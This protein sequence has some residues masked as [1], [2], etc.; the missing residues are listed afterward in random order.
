MLR[1]WRPSRRLPHPSWQS[2]RAPVG[3]LQDVKSEP[4]GL[5]TAAI[6][7]ARYDIPTALAEMRIVWSDLCSP[8]LHSFS[9]ADAR[10]QSRHCTPSPGWSEAS[11]ISF[12]TQQ[13]VTTRPILSRREP[14]EGVGTVGSSPLFA[15]AFVWE[16]RQLDALLSV[17]YGRGGDKRC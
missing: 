1:P 4:W 10:V 2:I 13:K 5:D 14:K 11:G 6:H 8:L 12:V 7:A 17:G 9:R 3:S 15:L 16:S